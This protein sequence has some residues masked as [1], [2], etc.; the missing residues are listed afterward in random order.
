MQGSVKQ[1]TKIISVPG[2]S[3]KL[4]NSTKREKAKSSGGYVYAKGLGQLMITKLNQTRVIS[5]CPL[6]D[7]KSK[8]LVDRLSQ[9]LQRSA[10]EENRSFIPVGKLEILICRSAIRKELSSTQNGPTWMRPVDMK[11][12]YTLAAKIC[13][14][15]VSTFTPKFK[16]PKEPKK[17]RSSFKKIFAILV[18]MRRASEIDHFVAHAV[19][20]DML[21]LVRNIQEDKEFLASHSEPE[22]V[23]TCFEHWER[24]DRHHFEDYQWRVLAPIFN[25]LEDGED[26]HL[27][28]QVDCVLPF[29]QWKCYARGGSACIYMAKIHPHHNNLEGTS[30]SWRRVE[31]LKVQPLIKLESQRCICSQTTSQASSRLPFL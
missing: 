9:A 1:Y 2:T 4:T 29:C 19:T 24:D 31:Q 23:L 11:R 17:Q 12:R 15:Q 30:V 20:D 8:S 5:D 25:Q 10:F 16:I 6:A 28:L 14:W 18:L 3:T 22:S 21:P 27:D 13:P 7:E 26:H